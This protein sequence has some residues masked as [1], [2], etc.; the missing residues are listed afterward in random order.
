LRVDLF[1]QGQLHS[2][3]VSTHDSQQN[4]G[5]LNRTK[6][7]PGF[8]NLHM[9]INEIQALFYNWELE[10]GKIMFRPSVLDVTR[11]L[12]VAVITVP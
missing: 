4:P 12:I 3:G 7:N 9:T 1:G 11:N 6:T 10:K 5:R 8:T 2:A